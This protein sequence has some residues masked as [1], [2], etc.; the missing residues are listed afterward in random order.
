[1]NI[2]INILFTKIKVVLFS[3]NLYILVAYVYMGVRGFS[4]PQP[5]SINACNGCVLAT[6]A[7][8]KNYRT[9]SV[10]NFHAVGTLPFS[11]LVGTAVM[12]I[13]KVTPKFGQQNIN[14]LCIFFVRN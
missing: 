7:F 6:Q 3:P 4:L 10:M 1:M 11:C 13:T 2:Y 14:I 5:L 9:S 12:Y 8:I